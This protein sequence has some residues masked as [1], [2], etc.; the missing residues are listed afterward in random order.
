VLPL[1]DSPNLAG[2]E[3]LGLAS[4]GITDHGAE[5]FIDSPFLA[6]GGCLVLDGNH[7]GPRVARRL[8][9][10]HPGQVSCTH[11]TEDEDDD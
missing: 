5:A 8:R 10:R 1:A 9:R 4:N 11:Q 6:A 7:V 2:V 3:Y